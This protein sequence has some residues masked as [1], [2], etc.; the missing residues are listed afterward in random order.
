MLKIWGRRTSS[1]VQALVWCLCELG[2]PFERIDAG[3]RFGLTDS[4]E[5]RAM[6]PNGLV[7][8]VSD[9][10]GAPIWETGAIMRYIAN[11]YGNPSFWPA[12]PVART[13]VDMWAE[14]AK[15]NVAINFGRPI[16]W[17]VIPFAPDKVDW[18]SVNAAIKTLARMLDIAEAR[19]ARQPFLCGE[20][21]TLADIQ[22][23]HPLFR[24]FDLPIERPHHPAVRAY[25]DRLC[26]RPAYREHVMVPYDELR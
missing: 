4:P 3:H 15:L 22:F 16:F 11:R 23:G 9:D 1:N 10:G 26:D 8:V 19:L 18:A 21:L 12:D 24:Y 6:N 25:Y 2:L 20:N 14:W 5:F 17:R 13:Q 7:P